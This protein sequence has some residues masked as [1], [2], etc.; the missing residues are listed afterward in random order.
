MKEL[1]VRVEKLVTD[2]KRGLVTHQTLVEELIT[3]L[4]EAY[5]L[6]SKDTELHFAPVEVSENL[7]VPLTSENEK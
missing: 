2:F 1:M 3:I 6:G 4:C 5:K 7:L